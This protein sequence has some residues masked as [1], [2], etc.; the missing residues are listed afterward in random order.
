MRTTASN[1]ERCLS[2]AVATVLGCALLTAS[3][4]AQSK[5]GDKTTTTATRTEHD[6]LGEKQVPADAYYGVQ[7]AARARELPAL[8]RRDQ[9]LPRLRRGL[10]DRQAGGGARQHRRR[11]DEAGAARHDREGL[12]GGAR[13]QVPRPVPGGLVPGRRRHL[14]EHERQRGAGQ[15]R[16]RAERAQEGRVPVPRAARRPQHVAVDERLVPD[17]DQGRAH[18]AQRQADRRAAEAGRVVP[19]EGQRVPRRS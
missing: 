17:R 12:P 14:D 3:A 11:R 8:R 13:R 19:R 7:T 5:Q 10:G 2:V 1:L 18:P 15:R 16:P 4:L 6:L 9:P